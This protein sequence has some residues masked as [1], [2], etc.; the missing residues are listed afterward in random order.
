MTTP[1]AP[2]TAPSPN[3][4]GIGPSPRLVSL[5]AL[6]GFDMMWIV[7]ADAFGNAFAHLRGGPVG[8]VLA[9]QLDHV[10]WV[11]F[12]FYDLIFPL[13]VFMIGV[14]LTFSLNRLIATEGR[15]GALR[16]V[17]RRAVLMY[18]LGLFYY[19]G[20][21]T[22]LVQIRLLGVL[23]RLALCYFLASLLF[24]YLRPRNLAV[25]CAGLL[26]GYW[27]LLTFVPVPGFGAGD[28]AEGH[29][30]TNW[31]DQHFL[32][33]RKWDGDHDP[34]GLLSTLPAVSSCLL[35]VFAGLLLRDATRTEK[36]KAAL[37]GG[38]GVA[39][40]LLG[41]LWGLQFPVI[42]KIWT[43]SYV[44][45]AGGWSLLL[46]AIFYGIIDG[47]KVRAWAT[48]FVWLGTNAITI[49]LISNVTD[50]GALSAR[51]TGGDVAA[52]LDARWS[53]LSGLALALVSVLL[54]M[55]VCR[56]LYQRKIFLRL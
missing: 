36:Q 53:G 14:A 7:G 46:L 41:H 37:L 17:F 23:Q 52:W 27:A 50:F 19:G 25:V 48:P 47:W 26:V 16:R 34:E 11:G 31:L 32:P 30:L 39:L 21:A 1:P 20:L 55:A 49:Y 35:G 9:T 4:A 40:V 8:R 29:N 15:A 13:F 51:F 2:T 12:H 56:F 10:S 28:F 24:I 18:L 44:L 6:R 33:G 38:A 42:K 54:C 22:P 5:D 3:S 45:V 43:S